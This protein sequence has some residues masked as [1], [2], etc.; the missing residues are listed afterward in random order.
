MGVS[1]RFFI[2]VSSSFI[3][4]SIK[5]CRRGSF[6]GVESGG[7]FRATLAEAA[8]DESTPLRSVLVDRIVTGPEDSTLTL[9]DE[10]MT[11]DFFSNTGESWYC[12]RLCS[13]EA[14]M[15]PGLLL[16]SHKDC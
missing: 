12:L 8:A 15:L 5:L 4:E 9:F 16:C 7:F 2:G 13:I 10:L 3:G 11:S 1:N 14:K 6:L